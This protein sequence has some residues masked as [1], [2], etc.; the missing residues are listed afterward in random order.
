MRIK[1]NKGNVGVTVALEALN[2]PV[3]HVALLKPCEALG[4]GSCGANCDAAVLAPCAAIG[5][6]TGADAGVLAEFHA[7]GEADQLQTVEDRT[8]A[9]VV[10]DGRAKFPAHLLAPMVAGGLGEVA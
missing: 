10:D 2:A 6:V 1:A 9:L 7:A 5:A 8:V 4:G 3:A